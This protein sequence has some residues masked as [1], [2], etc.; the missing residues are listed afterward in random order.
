[1]SIRGHIIYETPE[2]KYVM[3]W[4]MHDSYIAQR[5]AGLGQVLLEKFSNE[6]DINQLF[7]LNRHF[8]T[9]TDS[10][11]SYKKAQAENIQKIGLEEHNQKINAYFDQIL[12]MNGQA[13]K[14]NKPVLDDDTIGKVYDSLD[15]CLVQCEEKYVYLY[16]QQEKSWYI[17]LGDQFLLLKDMKYIHKKY[18][19]LIDLADT[20]IIQ[21]DN[22]E[23]LDF[24]M[25]KAASQLL[26]FIADKNIE[27]TTS[28]TVLML[29]LIQ[30][31]YDRE[32]GQVDR[33]INWI[34]KNSD[35]Y[36]LY[37]LNKK[38][39]KNIQNKQN[40]GKKMKI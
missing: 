5:N 38:L 26:K 11:T 16:K 36:D 21:T 34:Q 20:S 14:T 13:I 19:E 8:S 9:I 29:Y 10:E 37:K 24:K 2:G 31:N 3:R 18:N 6:K 35:Q 7:Q 4:H 27:Q 30:S 39:H 33:I 22:I 15:S 12:F 32:N 28:Y 1:M 40:E 17:K 23:I 25:N